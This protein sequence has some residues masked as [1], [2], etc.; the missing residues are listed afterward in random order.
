MPSTWCPDAI[1]AMCQG[2]LPTVAMKSC[3]EQCFAQVSRA[4]VHL[5]GR[6]GQGGVD[7]GF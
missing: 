7:W 1:A 5:W 2:M 3:H 4:D 6:T